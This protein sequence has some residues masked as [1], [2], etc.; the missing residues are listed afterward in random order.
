[1]LESSATY[2]CSAEAEI[3]GLFGASDLSAIRGSLLPAVNALGSV[4]D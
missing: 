1:V 2:I 4:I 3:E